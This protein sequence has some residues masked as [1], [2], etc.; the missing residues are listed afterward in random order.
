MKINFRKKKN[1]MIKFTKILEDYELVRNPST[2]LDNLMKDIEGLKERLEDT[3]DKNWDTD[4]I[5]DL[6]RVYMNH[7]TIK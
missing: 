6:Y 3:T 2:F 1:I 7:K 5:E 4:Y